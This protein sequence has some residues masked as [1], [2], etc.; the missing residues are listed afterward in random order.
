MVLVRAHI[1]GSEI[2]NDLVGDMEGAGEF[3]TE[4]ADLLVSDGNYD[5]L[6]HWLED[7]AA[8]MVDRS[9]LRALGELLVKAADSA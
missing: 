3:F 6:F 1:S 2:A 7:Y 8:S 5:D 4:F 9:R